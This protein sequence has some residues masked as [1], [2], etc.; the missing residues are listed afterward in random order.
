M[1]KTNRVPFY[2]PI[3][4]RIIVRLL[5]LGV[6]MG[7]MMLLTV[8]GRTTG[9]P[10]TTPVGLFQHSGHRWLL[11]TF[12]EVNWTRNLRAAGEGILTRGRR[13]QPVVALELAPEAAGPVLRDVLTP[14]LRSR[15]GASFL[16]SFYDLR[17]DAPLNDFIH[18]AQRHPVFELRESRAG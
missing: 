14:Y 1:P 9:Q 15:L 4:N 8:R 2:V 6:P 3:F 12:G 10:R 5:R 7:P 13:R 18:E 16:H 11:A 17:A